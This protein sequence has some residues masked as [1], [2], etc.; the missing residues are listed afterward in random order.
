MKRDMKKQYKM[1]QM[2]VIQL[3][4]TSAILAGSDYNDEINAPG[5]DWVE[6]AYEF[7]G[8]DEDDA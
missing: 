8:W 6:K 5:F 3:Q 4:Q 7:G 2:E 1:P